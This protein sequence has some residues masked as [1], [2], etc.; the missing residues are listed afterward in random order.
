MKAA[1]VLSVL[2]ALGSAHVLPPLKVRAG[3]IASR[4]NSTGLPPTQSKNALGIIAQ[5]KAENLGKQGCLAGITTAIT[6]VRYEL[7]FL[8]ECRGTCT[9]ICVTP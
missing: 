6:E 3:D 9:G 2:A 5:N 4:S 7:L 8:G 1:I